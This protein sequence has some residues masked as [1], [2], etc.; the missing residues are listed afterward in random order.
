MV[1][2]GRFIYVG[3]FWHNLD[4][5]KRLTV[6]AKWRLP[7][8]EADYYLGL[9]NPEGFISVYP[10][11]M[12]ERL[13]ERV[14]QISMGDTAAQATLMY[15]SSKAHSFGCDKSG[16]IQLNDALLEHADVKKESVLVGNFNTFSIWSPER[17]E[18]FKKKLGEKETIM[19]ALDKLG[20]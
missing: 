8:D 2:L 4:A 15:L 13:Q 10:P 11:K 14:A 1:E 19:G 12:I 6:P 20:L 7:G 17:Y 18:Q 3:E 9:P 16:R 5:K